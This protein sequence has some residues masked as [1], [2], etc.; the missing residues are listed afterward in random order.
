[1]IEC[2]SRCIEIDICLFQK[3]VLVPLGNTTEC[4][5]SAVQFFTTL[6]MILWWQWQNLDRT[7]NSWQT[8]YASPSLASYRVCVV[9]ILE[10]IWPWCSGTALCLKSW[11]VTNLNISR[12]CLYMSSD[13]WLNVSSQCIETDITCLRNSCRFH[14]MIQSNA[15]VTRSIFSRHYIQHY[16]ESCKT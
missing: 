3:L 6:H 8:T 12:M 11:Y 16:V 13:T 1:M 14:L 10:G 5:C 9:R 15:V 7:L 2:R 4:R